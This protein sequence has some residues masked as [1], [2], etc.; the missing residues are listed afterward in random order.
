MDWVEVYL[1]YATTNNLKQT[2]SLFVPLNPVDE[3]EDDEIWSKSSISMVLW[4]HFLRLLKNLF[5]LL[6]FRCGVGF[7]LVF[8][9][10]KG[11]S[12]FSVMT[13]SQGRSYNDPW[14]FEPPP[15]A[16][17]DTPPPSENCPHLL[18][19]P[20]ETCFIKEK[21]ISKKIS[22]LF[23]FFLHFI[24][25]FF[26]LSGDLT[27]KIHEKKNEEKQKKTKKSRESKQ[28]LDKKYCI[29][30][31]RKFAKN[32]FFWFFAQILAVKYS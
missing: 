8:N 6:H 4:Y 31:F 12:T 14:G 9:C 30:L 26:I 13:D 18:A 11:S 23:Y 10:N 32:T 19:L 24:L 20:I 17:E 7:G 22:I 15:P 1:S 2:E 21:M 29:I 3:W 5:C 16:S 25:L 27:A 28:T